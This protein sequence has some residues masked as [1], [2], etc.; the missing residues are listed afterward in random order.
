M[1]ASVEGRIN[2][3]LTS[4]EVVVAPVGD[5]ANARRG[6]LSMASGALGLD[7]LSKALHRAFAAT[8]V[9]AA[10]A[11]VG[12]SDARAEGV[13][14]DANVYG[15]SAGQVMQQ[16]S[17]VRMVVAG[18]RPVQIEVSPQRRSTGEQIGDYA[19][20]AAGGAIGA[21]VGNEIGRNSQA[22]R[23]IGGIA[24]GL[25]GAIAGNMVNT[26]IRG[27]SGARMIDGVELTLVNPV[28]NQISVVTQAGAQRF[29]EGDPVLMIN[30]GGGTRVIPD[31]SRTQGIEP[32]SA[33]NGATSLAGAPSVRQVEQLGQQF[34]VQVDANQVANMLTNGG[35]G[36]D[37]WHVGRVVGVDTETGLVFQST[38]RDRGIVYAANAL[39]RVP[40]VGEVVT[41]TMKN[42]RGS[43]EL[44]KEL[45][46]VDG[47]GRG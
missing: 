36:K 19:A 1:S 27:D 43:V 42:G 46:R 40:A 22:G 9:A 21:V 23:Q 35:R 8:V 39:D 33:V 38:G 31:Q 41:I 6:I 18:V 37:S 30:T 25:L 29:R 11:A 20:T 45:G 47:R 16:G 15:Q 17:G 3:I 7:G 32:R 34:G 13:G 28:S 5:V 12:V 26:A 24:G 44:P 14:Y 4:P 2:A 10:L